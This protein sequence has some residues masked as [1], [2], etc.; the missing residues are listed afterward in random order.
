MAEPEIK[1]RFATRKG[2]DK[3]QSMLSHSKHH[4]TFGL[5]VIIFV[6]LVVKRLNNATLFTLLKIPLQN[7]RNRKNSKRKI[8][9]IRQNGKQ[10]DNL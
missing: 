2:R 3:L 10:N 4:Q 5:S 7:L 1:W 9:K 8:L 6:K